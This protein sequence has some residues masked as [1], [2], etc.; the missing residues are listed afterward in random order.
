VRQWSGFAAGAG[1]PEIGAIERPQSEKPIEGRPIG[2]LGVF[3]GYNDA[4][5]AAHQRQ[6]Q[7]A[8]ERNELGAA[9]ALI[10]RHAVSIRRAASCATEL[11]QNRDCQSTVRNYLALTR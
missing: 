11:G 6:R 2:V 9:V 1:T 8:P 4:M 5:V 7:P 10:D 3:G